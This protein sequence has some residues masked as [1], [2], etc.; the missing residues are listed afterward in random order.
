MVFAVVGGVSNFA[1]ATSK[2]MT[3]WWLSNIF[4]DTFTPIPREMI[5]FDLRI[6]FKWVGSTT[7]WALQ[8][9]PEAMV[10]LTHNLDRC[11]FSQNYFPRKMNAIWF[12]WFAPEDACHFFLRLFF[13]MDGKNTPPDLVM[14]PKGR[15]AWTP[16]RLRRDSDHQRTIHG[17]V[18]HRFGDHPK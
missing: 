8:K 1:G 9:L 15:Y 17:N 18:S 13:E 16:S 5:Q 12:A 7:N 4:L 11:F 3:R 2:N 6:F 14:V 10:S